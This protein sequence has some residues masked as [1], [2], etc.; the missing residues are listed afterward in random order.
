MPTQCVASYFLMKEKN[1]L[2]DEIL[3]ELLKNSIFHS[4]ENGQ[5]EIMYEDSSLFSMSYDTSGKLL[6]MNVLE[7]AD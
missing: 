2:D 7:L 6:S 5:L 4:Q 1:M 3:N